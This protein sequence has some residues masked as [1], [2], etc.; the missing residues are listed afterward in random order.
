M[1]LGAKYWC[2]ACLRQASAG[3]SND[4]MSNIA[5]AMQGMMAQFNTWERPEP[6]RYAELGMGMGM[7]LLGTGA[8]QSATTMEK[9][10]DPNQVKEKGGWGAVT[11]RVEVSMKTQSCRG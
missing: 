2:Q 8:V 4:M 9:W 5:T 11:V 7:A 10:V 3:I 1:C 6:T